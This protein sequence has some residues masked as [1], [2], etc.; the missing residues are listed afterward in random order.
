MGPRRRETD[1]EV[2]ARFGAAISE[3][4]HRSQGTRVVVV[5]HGGAMRAFLRQRFGP[6][7]LPGSCR[8]PN[9]SITRIRWGRNGMGPELLDLAST[10]HL[11]GERGPDTTR[12]E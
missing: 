6:G 12:A 1:E 11:S 2:M 7:V 8:A 3:V 4:R 10:A 5:S 9:A